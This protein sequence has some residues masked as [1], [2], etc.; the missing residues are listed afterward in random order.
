VGPVSAN[1]HIRP[2][3]GYSLIVDTALA[4]SQTHYR[5]D[6]CTDGEVWPAPSYPFHSPNDRAERNEWWDAK[7]KGGHPP[8]PR[9]S[10]DDCVS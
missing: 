1:G 7:G 9:V 10:Y 3:K 4:R 8:S 2:K 6:D 5:Q